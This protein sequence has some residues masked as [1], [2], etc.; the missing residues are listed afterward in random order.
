[1]MCSTHV[2]RR[3]TRCRMKNFRPVNIPLSPPTMPSQ[4]IDAILVWAF[5]RLRSLVLLSGVGNAKRQLPHT[6]WCYCNHFIAIPYEGRSCLPVLRGTGYVALGNSL[7]DDWMGNAYLRI[8]LL[9]KIYLIQVLY[10]PTEQYILVDHASKLCGYST[11]LVTIMGTVR[12]VAIAVLVISFLTFVAFF[13]R[14][15]ALRQADSLQACM[16]LANTGRNNPIGALYRL[17]WIHIPG[18]FRKLDQVVTSGR[19]SAWIGK[20]AHT[21]WNDRHPL[22]MV[23][24]YKLCC[25]YSPEFRDIA[26]VPPCQRPISN[27]IHGFQI[28]I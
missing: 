16:L 1:M 25:L 15:P 2:C 18:G 21:L 6:L 5:V 24:T 8:P 28:S 7:V 12:N 11:T 19:L 4:T 27:M 3:G 17:I 9:G 22:V 26:L 14:L 23:R 13:G 10:L 20:L